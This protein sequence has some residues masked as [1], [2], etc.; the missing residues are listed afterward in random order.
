M[1]VLLVVLAIIAVVLIVVGL[2]LEALRWLLIIGVMALLGG[3]VIAAI[4]GRRTA[5]KS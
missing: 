2:L 3:L 4:Q 1:S 5:S